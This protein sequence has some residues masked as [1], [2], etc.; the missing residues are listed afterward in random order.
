MGT[1]KYQ[2][3]GEREKTREGEYDEWSK[4]A[5]EEFNWNLRDN[6]HATRRGTLVQSRPLF[7]QYQ[8]CFR[9]RPSDVFINF[10]LSYHS[11]SAPLHPAWHRSR[12]RIKPVFQ[13]DNTP[14]EFVFF[15]SWG[16]RAIVVNIPKTPLRLS[17]YCTAVVDVDVQYPH[18]SARFCRCTQRATL[19]ASLSHYLHKKLETVI[20]P[21]PAIPD[22][23]L[24]AQNQPPV[25]TSRVPR[26]VSASDTAFRLT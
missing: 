1:N 12:F 21:L 14:W 9:Q 20:L 15:Y 3:R 11:N 19:L 22:H 13:T 24:V 16:Y 26:S 5:A 6:A 17:P 4:E 8:M 25:S 7:L 2:Q 18:S 10:T 23:N